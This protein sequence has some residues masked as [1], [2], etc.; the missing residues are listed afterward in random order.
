M[1]N[2]IFYILFAPACGA[3][4]NRL[5]YMSESV[6][7]ADEAMGRLDEILQE[8]PLAKATQPAHPQ[9]CQVEFVHV[10]FTYPKACLLYTS[11]CV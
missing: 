7:E 5:M 10:T 8:K 6:M 2:F 1:V 3:M 11:R 9:G 4:I